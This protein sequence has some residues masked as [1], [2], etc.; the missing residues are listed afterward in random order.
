MKKHFR[1]GAFYEV[2]SFASIFILKYKMAQS[3][4]NEHQKSKKLKIL[5]NES[6]FLRL[7]GRIIVEENLGTIRKT[8]LIKNVK[9][10]QKK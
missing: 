5:I 6:Q 4:T 7:A 9:N 1:Y 10:G 8:F 3:L 2:N